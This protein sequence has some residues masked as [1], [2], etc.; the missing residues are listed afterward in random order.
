MLVARA[1][2]HKNVT[3]FNIT[4]RRHTHPILE[5]QGYVRYCAGRFVAVPTLSSSSYGCRVK[6]V[7]SDIIADEHLPSS[8]VELLLAHASYGCISLTCRSANGVQPFVFMPRKKFGLPFAYLAYCRDLTE[9]VRFAGPLGRFLAG[10]GFPVVV[11]DSNG[12]IGG[13]IGI[14]SDG[15]PKYFKGPVRPGLGDYAYSERVMFGV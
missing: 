8:E 1:L 13:L 2:K 15:F 3:Y 10:R 4:P 12:P 5:A 14:Y 9:F 6:A 11:L 7:T